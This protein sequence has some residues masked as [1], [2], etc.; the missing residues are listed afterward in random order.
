MEKKRKAK[1][2]VDQKVIELRK[3]LEGEEANAAVLAVDMDELEK[4]LQVLQRR[5][6]LTGAAT[7]TCGGACLPP[8]A[9]LLGTVHTNM[10]ELFNMVN[11]VPKTVTHDT[12][13]EA[14]SNG[15]EMEDDNDDGYDCGAGN[16]ELGSMVDRVLLQLCL[17]S[18]LPV[19]L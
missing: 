13:S 2:A 10:A 18:A 16:V 3:Q 12:S 8:H 7:A 1:A 5:A 19:G 17:L 11:A 14:G 6:M 4:E 15:Q 9:A